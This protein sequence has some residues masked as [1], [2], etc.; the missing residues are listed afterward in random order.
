MDNRVVVIGGGIA[1]IQACLDLAEAGSKVTLVERTPSIGGKMAALDKN[2]PTLDCSICIEAPKISEVIQNENIEVLPLAEVT[3]VEGSAGAF[4]VTIDQGARYVTDE[5]TRCDDCVPPCPQILPNEFD[6]GVGARKA[7]YTPFEQAEPGAYTIDIDACLNE[8]P[9]YLPCGLCVEACLPKCIDFNM[10]AV[11]RHVR[12]AA[13]IIVTTGFDLFD[14]RNLPEYGYGE[15]PDILT[16]MEFE[17]LLNAAGP[18]AGEVV[19]PSDGTQPE[20]LLFVLCVGSRDQ[21]FCH[22]C[23]RVC[24]MYSI[25]EAVQAVDHGIEDVTVLYMDIRAYGKGFDD[26]FHRTQE[27]G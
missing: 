7:I 9:N 27:E 22:Y 12:E 3:G 15:H 5:C 10:K 8:P 14:P 1:G 21:R 19:K 6:V 4:T 20:R 18:T 16:S 2:F 23:S 24:C 13:A 26:F 25:K 11:T 17:R